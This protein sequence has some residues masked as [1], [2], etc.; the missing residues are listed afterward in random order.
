M[1][2]EIEVSKETSGGNKVTKNELTLRTAELIWGNPVVLG[3]CG[4]VLLGA[5]AILCA[6]NVVKAGETVKLIVTAIGSLSSGIAIGKL[7]K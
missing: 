5:L 3:I 4:L 1:S 2:E 6:E 7:S